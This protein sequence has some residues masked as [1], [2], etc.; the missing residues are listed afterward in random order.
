M[1][2]FD[3][4]ALILFPNLAFYEEKGLQYRFQFQKSVSNILAYL[5]SINMEP[6]AFLTDDLAWKLSNLNCKWVSTLNRGDLFFVT[7]NCG[8]PKEVMKM[9]LI[10]FPNIVDPI[11]DKDKIPPKASVEERFKHVLS[12]DKKAITSIIPTYKVV[13]NFYQRG[14]TRYRVVIKPNGGKIR[15]VVDLSSFKL[16]AY[17]NN[18]E[19][20]PIDLLNIKYGN[21]SLVNWEV[22]E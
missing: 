10:E 9:P 7:N 22:T 11:A 14:Q 21:K 20:N 1:Q 8:I 4:K 13:V 16:T 3:D 12:R 2:G 5:R 6:H 19:E 18:V 17:I 15:L